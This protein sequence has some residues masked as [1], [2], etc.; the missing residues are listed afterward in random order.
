M[1]EQERFPAILFCGVQHLPPAQ[2]G[3][4][5]VTACRRAIVWWS[6]AGGGDCDS[7]DG[8]D[9]SGGRGQGEGQDLLREV[10]RACVCVGEQ[11]DI[12]ALTPESRTL[13]F[14]LMPLSLS[15]MQASALRVLMSVSTLAHV[16]PHMITREVISCLVSTVKV[17]SGEAQILAVKALCYLSRWQVRARRPKP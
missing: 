5:G 6:R 15:Q 13:P 10:C 12:P 7:E 2:I 1:C 9:C 16:R 8:S 14:R 11:L 4:R 17:D 3:G